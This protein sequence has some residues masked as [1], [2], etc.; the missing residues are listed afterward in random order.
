MLRN[1]LVT[2]ERNWKGLLQIDRPCLYIGKINIVQIIIL[3][4]A[5]CEFSAIPIK[6]LKVFFTELYEFTNNSKNCIETQKTLNSENNLE[7]EEQ[8][9]SN[10]TGWSETILYSYN[11]QNSMV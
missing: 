2:H 3:P 4:K 11:N 5:I 7:K 8:N 6:I 1:L 9:W 10:H